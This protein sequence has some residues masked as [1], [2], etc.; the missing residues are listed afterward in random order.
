MIEFFLVTKGVLLK[1]VV[2]L[3]ALLSSQVFASCLVY[4][5]PESDSGL[6]SYVINNNTD[7]E[8]TYKAAEAKI[9]I[10]KNSITRHE[11]DLFG[12]FTAITFESYEVYLGGELIQSTEPVNA[13]DYNYQALLQSLE[14]AMKEV[15]EF[16]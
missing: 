7:F 14:L 13:D 16:N 10:K 12:R 4:I 2:I 6:V 3:V 15:C 8:Q 5:S 1:I 9:N 11:D